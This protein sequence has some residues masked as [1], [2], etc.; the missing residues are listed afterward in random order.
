MHGATM[1]YVDETVFSE[2]S[3]RTYKTTS[4]SS[5]SSTLSSSTPSSSSS[6]VTSQSSI[7]PTHLTLSS[8]VYQIVFFQSV[9]NSALF[10]PNCCCSFLLNV[11]I[12]LAPIFFSFM[13]NSFRFQILQKYLN[14]FCVQK[15]V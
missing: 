4:S 10:L 13:S 11:A 7:F 6:S 12:S 2:T 14:H 9:Y 5:S 3:L 1:R 8:I 15:G